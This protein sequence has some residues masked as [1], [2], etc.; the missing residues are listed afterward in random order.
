MEKQHRQWRNLKWNTKLQKYFFVFIPSGYNLKENP[1]FLNQV[2]VLCTSTVCST[3]SGVK[4]ALL[5]DR[6]CCAWK[7]T[8]CPGGGKW[9]GWCVERWGGCKRN[10]S[11]EMRGGNAAYGTG[12]C[13]TEHAW[14]IWNKMKTIYFCRTNIPYTM[15]HILCIYYGN[16]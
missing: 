12:R 5:T 14:S 8:N 16:I 13:W 10:G 9:G 11:L 15:S 2:P 7:G 3:E 1:C 6:D 4:E